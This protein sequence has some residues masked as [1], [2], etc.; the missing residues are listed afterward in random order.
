MPVKVLMPALSPTMTEGTLAKWHVKEGDTVES[1]DVIA[2]IE[3][4]KATMEVEAVDEGKIGKI[5]VAEGSEGV[6]VNEV[7]A[8]LLEEGEDDSALEGADTSAAGTAPATAEAPAEAAPAPSAAPAAASSVPAAPVSGGERVK[9][10]PLARRIAANEG[11][12]LA[13]VTGSGPRGRIVK[14]DVEAAKS[15]KPAAAA[16]AQAAQAA[17]SAPAA[18]APA[19]SGWNPDLTGLPEYE[20]IPNSGM[21]KTIARRLTESK[22]QVPHFYLTVDCE[23]DNLLATRKQLNDKA[24]EGVKIS[25]NDFIIRAVS[26]AL[27]K[28]PAANSIWTDKATLQCKKQDISVAVAIEGGLITPVVRDAGSKGL[29]EISTEM[30]TLAGKARDGK[31][32][33]E[34]YQGGTFSV[35]NLGMF[36]IKE[37]SA[38]INPP[39]GCILA[40]GAGEQRPVVKDGALAIAT[41]MSCTLSVD[42]RAVD[43]AVGAQFMAEF[44]KL[45]EDPLSM[46]L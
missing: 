4:D 42:H 28:V 21:R 40:V 24:G 22:Q 2:E 15:A 45:I 29:A 20:E 12:D 3:T 46:L 1:G 9:A 27:K 11:V 38:I 35:S 18:A 25:V 31:L 10:S 14:R 36:G 8:L 19:A 23:L 44:K 32:M 26:L 37:F 7:I 6:A 41:V 17:S 34:D 43:G 5:L 33:P 39:Q 16:A 13:A 30:K